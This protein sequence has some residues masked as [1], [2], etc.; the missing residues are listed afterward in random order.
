MGN[1]PSSF[2]QYYST[3]F[4]ICL[5]AACF[6]RP[7]QPP[8][9]CRTGDNWWVVGLIRLIDSVMWY[10]CSNFLHIHLPAVLSIVFVGWLVRSFK[11]KT[12]ALFYFYFLNWCNCCAVIH[13]SNNMVVT[14]CAVATSCCISDEPCQWEMANFDPPQLRNFLTD[15]SETQ[16]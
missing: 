16:T 12:I 10:N 4:G 8:T 15:R 2:D 13:V 7:T 9:L 5:T 6:L 11:V 1:K 14:A 3:T